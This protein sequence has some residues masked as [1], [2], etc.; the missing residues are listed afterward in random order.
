MNSHELILDTEKMI[1]F[2]LNMILHDSSLHDFSIGS[3]LGKNRIKSTKAEAASAKGA[4]EGGGSQVGGVLY[5]SPFTGMRSFDSDDDISNIAWNALLSMFIDP[6]MLQYNNVNPSMEESF[7]LF[8]VMA[9]KGFGPYPS[10]ADMAPFSVGQQ[11]VTFGLG[12]N[13]KGLV[14]A[15]Q[16]DLT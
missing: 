9:Y 7:G 14:T 8:L 11:V 16:E 13:L 2:I 12:Q 1:F 6:C 5:D 3:S 15:L 4:F 10:P